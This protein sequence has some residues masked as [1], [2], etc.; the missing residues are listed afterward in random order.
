MPVSA[1]QIEAAS[2]QRAH[3]LGDAAQLHKE[4]KHKTEPALNSRIGVF[5]HHAAGVPHEADRQ[6]EGEIPTLCL[7]DEA[8]RQAAADRMQ[9]QFG[10]REP[11]APL[12]RGAKVDM[13]EPR[14]RIEAEAEEPDLPRRCLED[15]RVVVRHRDVEGRAVEM[16]GPRGTADGAVVLGA[17]IGRADDQWLAQP[18]TQRLQLV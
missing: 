8:G 13:D 7:G 15:H 6:G 11:L 14:A 5:Q 10:H 18:V 3:Y 9:L 17:A 1:W 16:L 4:L 2:I 12:T